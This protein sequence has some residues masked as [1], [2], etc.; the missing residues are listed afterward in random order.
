V[1]G[2]ILATLLRLAT[3][4]VLLGLPFPLGLRAV[5]QEAATLVPWAW[6]VNGFFSVIGPAVLLLAAL[7]DGIALVAM[8]PCETLLPV[9]E[10]KQALRIVCHCWAFCCSS[11]V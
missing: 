7:C 8:L 11:V 10:C 9:E 5:A 1:G 2:R 4:G 6:G 3:L